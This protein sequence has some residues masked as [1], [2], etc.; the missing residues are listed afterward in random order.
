MPYT[1]FSDFY[2]DII[3]DF[4]HFNDGQISIDKRGDFSDM[5][6]PFEYENLQKRQI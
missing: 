3:N 4:S 6:A 1:T 2:K 5:S